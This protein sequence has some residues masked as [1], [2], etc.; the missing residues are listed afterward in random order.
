MAS[1]APRDARKTVTFNDEKIDFGRGGD[2]HQIANDGVQELTT[3]QGVPV[4]DDQNSLKDGTHGPTALEDF[5]FLEKFFHFD[6]ELIPERVV[7]ARGFGAH[8]FFETYES[9][10]D[11]TRADI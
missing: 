8:G 3:K 11:L 5:D 1:K 2:T 4:A 6:Y 10:A 7:H 9:L